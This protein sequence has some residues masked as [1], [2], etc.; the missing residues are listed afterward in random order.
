MEGSTAAVSTA[1]K[2]SSCAP[3]HFLL[4]L[5]GWHKKSTIGKCG[6]LTEKYKMRFFLQ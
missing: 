2:A 4:I 1:P 5:A 3:F 6:T